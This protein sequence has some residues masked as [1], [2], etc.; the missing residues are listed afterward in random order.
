MTHAAERREKDEGKVGGMENRENRGE[1]GLY[2]SPSTKN[3]P[4]WCSFTGTVCPK[5]EAML[6]ARVPEGRVLWSPG[7]TV[8][9]SW[10]LPCGLPRCR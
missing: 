1:L 4:R 10:S 7:G 8:S 3:T 5:E 9:P 2:G 6:E